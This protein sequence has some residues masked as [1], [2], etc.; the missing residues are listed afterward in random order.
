MKWL[1]Q[2]ALFASIYV[3]FIGTR[4]ANK[5]LPEKEIIFLPWLAYISIQTTTTFRNI[6]TY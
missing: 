2:L 3:R 1:D 4:N 5:S 6:N